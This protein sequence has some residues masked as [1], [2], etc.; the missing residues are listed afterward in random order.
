MFPVLGGM[1]AGGGRERLAT[2][3]GDARGTRVGMLSRGLVGQLVR[4]AAE[5]RCRFSRVRQRRGGDGSGGLAA[6]F[7]RF[8]RLRLRRR[9]GGLSV[10]QTAADSFG[11]IWKLRP[12]VRKLRTTGSFREDRVEGA[13]SFF[14]FRPTLNYLI[15]L[16]IYL[17]YHQI[18]SLL[19]VEPSKRFIIKNISFLFV[20]NLLY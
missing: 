16:L 7:R 6:F 12:G 9:G 11:V 1:F 2:A 20:C 3:V 13:D 10:R 17:F 8:G 5:V 14:R 19:K 4:T 18:H 15:K